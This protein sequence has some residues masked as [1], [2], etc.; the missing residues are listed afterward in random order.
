MTSAFIDFYIPILEVF[1]VELNRNEQLIRLLNN[2]N[3]MLTMEVQEKLTQLFADMI[4]K[5]QVDMEHIEH[6]SQIK[7]IYLLMKQMQKNDAE[8]RSLTRK[9]C[10]ILDKYLASL[11]EKVGS[12]TTNVNGNVRDKELFNALV[13]IQSKIGQP[14]R[15]KAKIVDSI[16]KMENGKTTNE[17]ET[18]LVVLDD[19]NKNEAFFCQDLKGTSFTGGS[20]ESNSNIAALIH[21]MENLQMFTDKIFDICLEMKSR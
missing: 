20:I 1:S 12:L 9:T 16:K 14:V 21:R 4:K 19:V 15:G 13:S 5:Q 18:N 6:N 2:N 3:K 7:L 11:Y 8:K 10:D 17:K